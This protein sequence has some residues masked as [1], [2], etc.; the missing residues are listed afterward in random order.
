MAIQGTFNLSNALESQAYAYKCWYNYNYGNN[1]MGISAQDMGEITQTWNGELANWQATAMDDENAYE[2]ED[3]D[4]ESAKDRGREQAENKTGY[5][6][7]Q[8]GQIA[9]TTGD[10]TMGTAGALGSTVLKGTASSLGTTLTG[11]LVGN[12]I[13]KIANKAAEEAVKSATEEA[14]KEAGTKALEEAGKELTEEAITEAGKQAIGEAA[15]TEASSKVAGKNVGWIVTAPLA[16]LMGTLYMAKKP[17]QP[18]KEACDAMQD[19]MVNSQ[20][21]LY[22]AQDDMSAAGDEVI[23]LSD[24]AQTYNEDA[25]ETIEENKSEYDSYKASY[26]ALMKKITAGETLTDDEKELL[27]ELI[28]LMQELGVGL[29]E[30]QEETTETAEDIYDEMGTY[31]EDY[32]N[33]AETVGEVQGVTDYAQSFD[34]STRTMCYIEAAS[35]GLNAASGANAAYQAGAFAASG[36]PFT[37]WAW[38]FSA[39]GAAGAAMSG[40][41][42]AQQFKWAGEVGTEIDMRETTQDIN[43]ETNDIYDESIEGYEGAMVGVEEMEL[44]MPEDFENPEEVVEQL[45]EEGAEALTTVSTQGEGEGNNGATSGLGAG[46]PAADG[47]GTGAAGTGGATSGAGTA[48]GQGNNA[49]GVGA[50][51][52]TGAG[53]GVDPKDKDKEEK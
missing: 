36:G 7:K 14:I 27:Q 44:E 15:S 9:R 48:G 26:D 12:T 24:E 32:D 18:Q 33:S 51:G 53:S 29:Q 23:A 30:T 38:A 43:S 41:G 3:D 37:A 45:G 19:E 10:A 20:N 25:N 46:L 5:D 34:E 47:T 50:Q 2:I 4:F 17:N 22:A 11:N 35:Q 39:A 8:G 31:Q 6:G 21:A 16:L 49:G 13:N 52:G 42:V 28:P 1:T 40:V